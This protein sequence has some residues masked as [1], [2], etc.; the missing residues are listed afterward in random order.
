MF[1]KDLIMDWTSIA[2]GLLMCLALLFI[3]YNIYVRY[4]AT[5]E[6]PEE[7][8]QPVV[9]VPSKS[10][11][12]PEPPLRV[13]E[14]AE[15][16]NVTPERALSNMMTGLGHQDRSTG[17]TTRWIRGTYKKIASHYIHAPG[18][19]VD[20]NLDKTLKAMSNDELFT[21]PVP[22]RAMINTSTPAFMMSFDDD[23][24][25]P[26][27]KL[28]VFKSG[29][30]GSVVA[31]DDDGLVTLVVHVDDLV[32]LDNAIMEASMFPFVFVVTKLEFKPADEK[33]WTIIPPSNSGTRVFAKTS[34]GYSIQDFRTTD[35]YAIFDFDTYPN[36]V[37]FNPE[38]ITR[39]K[40]YMDIDGDGR[41]SEAER[42]SYAEM[43]N[44]DSKYLTSRSDGKWML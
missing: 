13:D 40:S 16:V 8:N 18:S 44:Q 35:N 11:V 27:S 41:V 42:T 34:K 2:I 32:A 23:S 36:N 14:R 21:K 29:K 43:F 24:L 1:L 38:L 10:I 25:G 7:L 17:T 15:V 31:V 20:T 3:M 22:R 39:L 5:I 37:I 6:A 26:N 4:W 33:E 9:V 12:V 30:S 28:A 19:L